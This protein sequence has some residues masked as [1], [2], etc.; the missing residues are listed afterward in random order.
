MVVLDQQGDRNPRHQQKAQRASAPPEHAGSE[1]GKAR[2]TIAQ[3]GA[4]RR[5]ESPDQDDRRKRL[6]GVGGWK[7]RNQQVGKRRQQV[8]CNDRGQRAVHGP[9]GKQTAHHRAQE[10]GDNGG[11]L[12]EAVGF[13]QLVRSYEFTQDAVLRRR[14]GRRTHTDQIVGKQW[15]HAG[16]HGRGA[17]QLHQISEQHGTAFGDRVRERS[18]KGR[19]QDEGDD[20]DLLQQ[21][22]L[23]FRRVLRLQQRDRGEQQGVVRQRR[24]ELRGQ[25]RNHATREQAAVRISS[26]GHT[27]FLSKNR[28]ASIRQGHA[29]LGG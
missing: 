24:Q 12:H 19:Q 25:Y 21:G 27:G 15:V 9:V 23:P 28:R 6:D 20:E 7:A 10:N 13:D 14:V 16:Q 3:Q 17:E 22:H 18:D 5:E 26:R 2:I 29:G 11:A 1:Q 4:H 8:A